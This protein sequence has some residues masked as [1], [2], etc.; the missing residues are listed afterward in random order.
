M[1]ETKRDEKIQKIKELKQAFSRMIESAD[2]KK[3]MEYLDRRYY[4]TKSIAFT[5]ALG[6][7]YYE[8]QRSVVLAIRDLA[9][10]DR[11]AAYEE[12]LKAEDKEREA[13]SG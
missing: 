6:L 3:I 10:L 2:G 13:S 8:G 1:D 12:M 4:V 9:D 5:E 11:Q 7:A